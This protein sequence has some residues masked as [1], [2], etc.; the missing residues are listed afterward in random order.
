V[1]SYIHSSFSVCPFY[2]FG[3]LP[4]L[5]IGTPHRAAVKDPELRTETVGKLYFA[6]GKIFSRNGKKK[7]STREV[8]TV[9]KYSAVDM[10]AARALLCIKRKNNFMV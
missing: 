9:G 2:I 6:N 10:L 7:G 5:G 4:L 8:R 3:P 1:C